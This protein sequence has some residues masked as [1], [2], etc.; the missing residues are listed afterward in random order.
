MALRYHW[1]L[2]MFALLCGVYLTVVACG[3]G[4]DETETGPVDSA[5]LPSA[6]ASG[7]VPN[8]AVIVFEGKRYKAV[9][10]HEIDTPTGDVADYEE[11]GVVEDANVPL[12]GAVKVYRRDNDETAIY[13]RSLTPA[14]GGGDDTLLYRWQPIDTIDPTDES[15]GDEN[16]GEYEPR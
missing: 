3:D 16:E 2:A 15:E 13:T 7:S 10:V 9:S 8:D 12:S 14:E 5:A 4:G 6:A 1:L 11:V